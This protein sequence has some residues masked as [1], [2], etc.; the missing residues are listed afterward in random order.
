MQLQIMSF[1]RN[2]ISNPNS[3][4]IIN[5]WLLDFMVKIINSFINMNLKINFVVE[6]AIIIS[7]FN[8]KI[9]KAI[10]ALLVI[11]TYS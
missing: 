1:F 9:K 10:T 4:E 5:C 7:S 6:F 8:I 11:N 3:I 2:F